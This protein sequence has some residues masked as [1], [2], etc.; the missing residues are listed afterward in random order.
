MND[1]KNDLQMGRFGFRLAVL[2]PDL[3]I[4]GFA[5]RFAHH[6]CDFLFANERFVKTNS[7][8]FVQIRQYFFSNL[9]NNLTFANRPTN[10]QP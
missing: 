3:K 5:N 2:P 9:R 10:S 6:F 7:T 4:R 8:F 1:L